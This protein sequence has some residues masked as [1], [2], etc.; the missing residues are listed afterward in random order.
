MVA[1]S[2][3]TLIPNHLFSKHETIPE[4]TSTLW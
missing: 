1:L 2:V 4:E 3:F